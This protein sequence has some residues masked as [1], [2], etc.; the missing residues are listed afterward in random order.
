ME[1]DGYPGEGSTS[2]INK[3]FL[4]CPERNDSVIRDSAFLFR[5]SFLITARCYFDGNYRKKKLPGGEQ[6]VM[7]NHSAATYEFNI[8]FFLSL[9]LFFIFRNFT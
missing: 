6:I 1:M 2:C 4:R 9:F 5:F 3:V 7:S 8:W